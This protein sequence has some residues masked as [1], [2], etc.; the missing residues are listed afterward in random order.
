M[1]ANINNTPQRFDYARAERDDENNQG[2]ATTPGGQTAQPAEANIVAPVEQHG[3]SSSDGGGD[4]AGTHDPS[5]TPPPPVEAETTQPSFARYG[6]G[7]TVIMGRPDYAFARA[8]V[9]ASNNKVGNAVSQQSSNLSPSLIQSPRQPDD[10]TQ[11]PALVE[12]SESPSRREPYLYPGLHTATEQSPHYANA[13]AYGREQGYSDDEVMKLAVLMQ[14][15]R[16]QNMGREWLALKPAVLR[17]AV[18]AVVRNPDNSFDTSGVFG[19]Q[20]GYHDAVFASQTMPPQ[21][22]TA[23]D[24]NPVPFDSLV[25]PEGWV[26][27]ERDIGGGD[28]GPNI[29]RYYRP[30][31]ELIAKNDIPYMPMLMSGYVQVPR[32]LDSELS[33]GADGGVHDLS[34][35]DFHPDYGLVTTPDNIRPL[36]NED[37]LDQIVVTAIIGIATYGI[38]TAA[39]GGA[40]ALNSGAGLLSG[41]TLSAAEALALSSFVGTTAATGDLR[42]GFIA[43]LASFAGSQVARF[44]VGP[45]GLQLNIS[46]NTPWTVGNFVS[47]IVSGTVSGTIQGDW[48]RGLVNG[49][50]SFSSNVIAHELKIPATV[51]SAA[52]R[53]LYDPQGALN[54]FITD[55]ITN[56]A[57]VLGNLGSG[58][59]NNVA[60]QREAAIQELLAQGMSLEH[61]NLA[62]DRIVSEATRLNTVTAQA[63]AEAQ[64]QIT[65]IREAIDSGHPETAA[66]FFNNMVAQ[67]AAE[68]PNMPRTEIADQLMRA[69]GIVPD[70]IGFVVGANGSVTVMP[71]VD[72]PTAVARLAAA[73]RLNDPTISQQEAERAANAYIDRRGIPFVFPER[74]LLD[75]VVKPDKPLPFTTGSEIVDRIIG[76]VQGGVMTGYNYVSGLLHG[77]A[78]ITLLSA[79]GLLD[80]VNK[81]I[82]ED[83]FPDSAQRNTARADMFNN[84]IA[85]LDQLPAQVAQYFNGRLERANQMDAA[86]DY[87]GA[88][89]ERTELIGDLIS[90]VTNPR[91]PSTM[92]ILERLGVDPAWFERTSQTQRAF[93]DAAIAQEH[94]INP[95]FANADMPLFEAH[96]TIPINAFS[97]LNGLRAQL[98][99]WGIDINSVENGVMLPG[100][101]APAGMQGTYHALLSDPG[102]GTELARRFT[103]VNDAA[104]ARQVL[105]AINTELRNGTFHFERKG[106]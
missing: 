64:Q 8:N 24:E 34:R 40:A 98:Q 104:T 20:R 56:P 28:A 93:R 81:L 11:K 41:G 29:I 72:R 94:R 58:Q 16:D 69:L 86:G 76:A 78:D 85:N 7:D 35:L 100:R 91:T 31:D 21:G 102:Y 32:G 103:G 106:K 59:N 61:A 60:A 1:A 80:I 87:I 52:I 36:D 99:R 39:A 82:G 70:T 12:V 26:L 95:A 55:L 25:P 63:R 71:R 42:Q 30:S 97:E 43:G 96:H 67:A 23:V 83:I 13:L 105:A 2:E 10:P 27:E 14:A 101:N 66:G 5:G 33:V 17:A 57:S 88:A 89:R 4:E 62:V 92:R 15:N 37:G 65:W 75:I 22:G 84:V 38:A 9:D 48:R 3:Q 46:P 79:D 19:G 54:G 45:Q 73:Y 49:L 77:V 50:V 68:N 6:L 74:L 47:S 53:A 44:I 18:N 90:M 51:A